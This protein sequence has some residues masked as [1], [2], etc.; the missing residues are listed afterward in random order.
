MTLSH[1]G[2]VGQD[3]STKRSSSHSPIFRN[4]SWM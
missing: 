4:D 3:I 2:T 1:K